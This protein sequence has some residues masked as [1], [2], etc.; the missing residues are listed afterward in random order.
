[1]I[2]FE[3]ECWKCDKWHT[4]KAETLA[5]IEEMSLSLGVAFRLVSG[6]E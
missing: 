3:Y 2:N 4:D 1:M 5:D 6:A